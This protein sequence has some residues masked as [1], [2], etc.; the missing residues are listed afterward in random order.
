[1]P[2]H[3][4]HQPPRREGFESFIL[5]PYKTV[6]IVAGDMPPPARGTVLEEDRGSP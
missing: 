5:T 1:M 2:P 4:N 3:P 6:E